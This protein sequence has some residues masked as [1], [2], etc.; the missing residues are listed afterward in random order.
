MKI[1]NYGNSERLSRVMRLLVDRAERGELPAW[2]ERVVLLPI[3]SARDGVHITGTDKLMCEVLLDVERGDLVAG[4]GIPEEDA[5]IIR[6]AGGVLYDAARDES[7]LNENS[8]LSALGATG[9]LITE[10]GYDLRGAKI[11]LVGWGRIGSRLGGMLTFHG[12]ELKVFTTSE[13]TR[14]ALGSCGVG[15]VRIDS[16]GGAIPVEGLDIL[17]NTAP[18]PLSDTF[19]SGAVEGGLYVLDLAS[20]EPFRGVR[21][22]NKLPSIPD[23]FF[24][25]AAARAFFS[26]LMA[27][28]EVAV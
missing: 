10:S 4:Y 27:A 25:D 14:I 3:P 19:E 6:A 20:G 15:T 21:G 26:G 12:A 11:G 22:V 17:I 7:F 8:R 16:G 28:L 9:F 5:E 18:I 23:R 13:R 1:E 24:P 2:V